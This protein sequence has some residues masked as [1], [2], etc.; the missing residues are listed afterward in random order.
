MDGEFDVLLVVIAERDGLPR[1]GP[2]QDS[3]LGGAPRAGPGCR[4]GRGHPA[5]EREQCDFKRRMLISY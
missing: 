4:E 3:K 1:A 5:E 2:E